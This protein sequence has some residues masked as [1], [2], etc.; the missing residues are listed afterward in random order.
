MNICNKTGHNSLTMHI[1]LTEDYRMG[2]LIPPV[3]DI[4]MILFAAGELIRGA[5]DSRHL[6]GTVGGRIQILD[7][8][9]HNDLKLSLKHMCREAIRKHL[10]QMSNLI[11]FCRI[12]RLVFPHQLR[13]YL[14][15]YMSIDD[16]V[17][18]VY[19]E[20]TGLILTNR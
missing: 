1:M 7:N 9:L 17:K 13:D 6:A 18:H 10:L 8:L 16:A 4:C 11:L 3:K 19:D 5:L 12:P 2:L 14:L 20:V 15:Y